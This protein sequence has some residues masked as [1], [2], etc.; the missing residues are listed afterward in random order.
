[1][2]KKNKWGNWGG[3]FNKKRFEWM[4]EEKK[5]WLKNLTMEKALKLEEALIS[6]EFIWE[7]RKNFFE[8]NPVSLEIGLKGSTVKN[9]IR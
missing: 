8:D 7:F 2:N 5:L 1:M 9:V 4:E 6:S 3:L